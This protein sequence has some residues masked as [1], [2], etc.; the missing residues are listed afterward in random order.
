MNRIKNILSCNFSFYSWYI[1][2]GF[3]CDVVHHLADVSQTST[4]FRILLSAVASAGLFFESN[5]F[6]ND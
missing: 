6:E 1:K 3:L 5:F 4:A 2:R